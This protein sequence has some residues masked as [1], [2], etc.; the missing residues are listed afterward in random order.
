M[1]NRRFVPS[2]DVL[3]ERIAPSTFLPP[4]DPGTGSTSTVT[5]TT[6][7]DPTSSTMTTCS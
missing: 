3:Q 5:T 2:V 6:A 1:R 4:T 7:T